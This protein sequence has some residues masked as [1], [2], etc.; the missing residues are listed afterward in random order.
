M[1]V[2]AGVRLPQ[3]KEWW[4]AVVSHHWELERQGRALP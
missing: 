1:E 3:A 2:G 4:S